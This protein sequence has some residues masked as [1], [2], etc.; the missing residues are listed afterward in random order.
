MQNSI[1]TVIFHI[2]TILVVLNEGLH[3][4]VIHKVSGHVLNI[5]TQISWEENCEV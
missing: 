4:I 2:T 1:N 5:L 3:L